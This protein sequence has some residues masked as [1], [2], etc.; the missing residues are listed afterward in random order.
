MQT[1]SSASPVAQTSAATTTRHALSVELLNELV[2]KMD[3]HRITHERQSSE[4][5][6][7]DASSSRCLPLLQR[8]KEV[9]KL[10]PLQFL[11]PGSSRERVLVGSRVM[12]SVLAGSFCRHANAVFEYGQLDKVRE[13]VRAGWR[14][15]NSRACR[16]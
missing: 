15:S 2:D 16:G 4:M 3:K 1:A 13:C 11:G 12:R 7:N 14:R 5:L 10:I 8:A 9:L 6:G